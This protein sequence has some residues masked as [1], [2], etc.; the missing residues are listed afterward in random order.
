MY[1][2]ILLYGQAIGKSMISEKV[3]KLMETLLVTVQPYALVFGKILGQTVAAMIQMLVWVASLIA[4]FLIGN[5]VGLIIDPEYKNM[6]YDVFDMVR[7]SSKHAFTPTSIILCVIA[8]MVGFLFFCIFAGLVTAGISKVEDL[9]QGM[10]V[11]T[12]LV[13]IGFLASYLIPLQENTGLNRIIRLVPIT[14][15]FILP[16]DILVGRASILECIISLIVLLICIG[17]CVFFTGK[18]YKDKIGRAHV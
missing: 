9:A 12:M 17:I 16:G 11:F 1:L 13:V 7:Q 14:G 2:M 5:E 4:G 6:I 18:V 3:S 10:G 15:A 8:L